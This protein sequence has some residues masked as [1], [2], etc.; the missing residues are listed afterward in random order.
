M[1]PNHMAAVSSGSASTPL[2]LLRPV[3]LDR[4]PSQDYDLV[5]KTAKVW[6]GASR[7][8]RSRQLV[9][10]KEIYHTTTLQ[11]LRCTVRIMHPHV[12]PVLALYCCRDQCF[13]VYEFLELDLFDVLPLATEVEIASVMAQARSESPPPQDRASLT[14][15]SSWTASII[16]SRSHSRRRS[17][18]YASHRTALS[19]LVL[20]LVPSKTY[21]G[22]ADHPSSYGLG[23][24]PDE[25]IEPRRRKQVRDR[26]S[27]G[28][29]R[30]DERERR[31]PKLGGSRFSE[32]PTQRAPP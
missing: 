27:G 24:R 20:H 26:L 32:V 1:S 10:I 30:H 21:G 3:Y 16:C 23:L 18:R 12:A 31:R 22:D 14:G 8:S 17:T 13:A 2:R 29:A 4:H 6:I 5:Q 15:Y 9:V 11:E 28:T 19:S 7:A 25:L